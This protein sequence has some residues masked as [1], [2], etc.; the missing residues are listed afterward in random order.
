MT[1]DF[2]DPLERLLRE[3]ARRDL[4]EDG[5]CRAVAGRLPRPRP[6]RPWLRPVLVVGSAA[7]GAA[8]AWWLA[9]TGPSVAQGFVDLARLHA[10]TPSA[11]FALGLALTTTVIAV[12]LADEER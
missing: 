2:Q 6:S 8:L 1:E 12:V 7:I 3:D 5:F 10:L 9:P 4:P 11:M